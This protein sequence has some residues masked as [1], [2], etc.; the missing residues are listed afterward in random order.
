M[1][2]IEDELVEATGVKPKK[3]RQ[4][5]LETLMN[6]IAKLDEESEWEE[7]SEE[8]KEWYNKNAKLVKRGKDALDFPDEDE[9]EEE[10]EEDEDKEEEDED[11]KPSKK[12]TKKSKSKDEDDEDEDSDSDDEDETTEEEDED[13]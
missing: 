2:K 6:K 8:A 10:E 3:D 11:E 12:K 9:E 5:Y 1:S 13:M 7:L 4:K